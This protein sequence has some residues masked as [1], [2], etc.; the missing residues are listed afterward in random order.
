LAA[1]PWE[2]FKALRKYTDVEVRLINSMRG[3][4]DGRFFPADLVFNGAGGPVWQWLDAAEI[5]HV[6]NY[7][8][9]DLQQKKKGH[10]VLAQFHSVPR[11]GNWNALMTW[12]DKN[13]TICQPLQE[14][15][16]KLPALPN[17]ID[18]DEYRPIRR[19]DR[20][21][22]AFAPS[23]RAPL[24]HLASKGYA[25]VNAVLRAVALKRD[26]DIAL[27]EGVPYETNLLLKQASQILVDDVISGNWHR[28]S[29]E[30]ACFGCAVLNRCPRIP[31]VQASIKTLEE[32]LL[33]LIDN[34]G[35]LRDIQEQT[36]IWVQESWHGMDLVKEY[37]QA[38]KELAR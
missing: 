3:Y 32:R 35:I 38:Y 36:R 10:R 12:A 17:I 9:P 8:I 31:W 29:L 30:G 6:N 2:L 34:P 15:E 23:S 33:W 7:L 25:E 16:Y 18:P 13:Y 22:I 27:I 21:R 4:P 5:W 26:V 37:V 20:I 19:G 28:T 1:A 14:R 11:L 24:G